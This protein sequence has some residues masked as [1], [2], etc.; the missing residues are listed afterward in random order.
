MSRA[1]WSPELTTGLAAMDELQ[2]EFCETMARLSTAADHEFSEAYNGLVEKAEHTFAAEEQWMEE[3]DCPALRTHREQH[4][5]VLG[6]LHNVHGDVMGGD[7]TAARK[8]V[9]QLLPDWFYLH[10]ST[11]NM[12]LAL[13]VQAANADTSIKPVAPAYA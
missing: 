10:A 13:A 11:M 5:R 4:A 3:I 9:G 6:A 7:L 2:L 1:I 12:A 8:V